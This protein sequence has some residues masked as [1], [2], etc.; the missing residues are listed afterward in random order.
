MAATVLPQLLSFRTAQE[1]QDVKFTKLLQAD[2]PTE[3]LEASAGQTTHNL[4][5]R[6]YAPVSS[7]DWEDFE[8]KVTPP[9]PYAPP[10][11]NNCCCL[12]V[13]Y[14]MMRFPCCGC[15]QTC[16]QRCCCSTWKLQKLAISDPDEL[17][18]QML[19]VKNPA[20]PEYLK[21]IWWMEDDVA[22]EGLLTFQDAEWFADGPF[23]KDGWHGWSYASNSIGGLGLIGLNWLSNPR[24][25]FEPAPGGRWIGIRFSDR[26]P[27]NFI[28]VLNDGDVL[29][30]PDGSLV[31]FTP[32]EDL[33]RQTF[34][35][36]DP[37]TPVL[38]QYLVRRVAYLDA[39][40]SLV[41]TKH[42]EKLKASASTST[43][44]QGLKN[45]FRQA[46][47]DFKWI[48]DPQV[49]AISTPELMGW[50]S[51]ASAPAQ[52]AMRTS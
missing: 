41:K 30:R 29:R 20:C 50:S 52:E 42:Y 13:A 9:V 40:G 45:C 49:V 38:Y 37:Q 3:Q 14:C 7:A 26:K 28:Y 2:E 34:S 47:P 4:K 22:P 31:D 19:S 46:A 36:F 6:V 21:G 12:S 17:F 24:T 33:L 15:V 43:A 18:M 8:R 39:D 32:G 25:Q 1:S 16:T 11:L 27:F 44:W 5:P 51:T 10:Q 23:V 35:S 48:A